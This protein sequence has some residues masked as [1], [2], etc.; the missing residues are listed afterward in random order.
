MS[1]SAMVHGVSSLSFMAQPSEPNSHSRE[2][3]TQRC[4]RRGLRIDVEWLICDPVAGARDLPVGY[5]TGY[6]H[7]SAAGGSCEP[8]HS[9]WLDYLTLG[10]LKRSAYSGGAS[11]KSSA[12]FSKRVCACRKTIGTV[13]IGPLRCLAKINSAIPCRSSRSR[14]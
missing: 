2:E 9:H 8:W 11:P 14:L 10:P 1:G 3:Q 4:R 12:R 6:R 7:K 5:T 13:P